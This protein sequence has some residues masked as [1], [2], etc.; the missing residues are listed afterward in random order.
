MSLVPTGIA[1]T[2]AFPMFSTKKKNQSVKLEFMHQFK[3]Q[4]AAGP[5]ADRGRLT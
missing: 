5:A 2:V 1:S 3:L 4:R